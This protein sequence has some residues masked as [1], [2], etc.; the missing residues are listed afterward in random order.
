MKLLCLWR[1]PRSASLLTPLQTQSN[2]L[3]IL[4]PCEIPAVFI[5][6]RAVRILAYRSHTLLLVNIARVIILAWTPV[7]CSRSNIFYISVPPVLECNKSRYC[8]ETCVIGSIWGSFSFCGI[9]IA[10][11]AH[12]SLP[13]LLSARSNTKNKMFLFYE[14]Q[15]YV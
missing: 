3:V 12:A 4:A 13:I 7:I 6:K 2:L 11:I 10:T 8:D 15:K 1:V 14:H 5:S 9:H